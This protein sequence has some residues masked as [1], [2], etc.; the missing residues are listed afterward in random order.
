[1]ET[2]T[3]SRLYGGLILQLPSEVFAARRAN[4]LAE[5]SDA[6]GEARRLL[7]QLDPIVGP[8]EAMELSAGI[9]AL[10][11]DVDVMRLKNPRQR[12]AEFDPEW[13]NS[14]WH[15]GYSPEATAAPVAFGR[16]SL[17]IDA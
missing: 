12:A 14:P 3:I 2:A 17:T 7:R 10:R 6:L 4:W 11:R 5:L 15:P 1:M 8:G 16:G 9:D 13:I